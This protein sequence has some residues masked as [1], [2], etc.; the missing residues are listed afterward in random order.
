MLKGRGNNSNLLKDTKRSVRPS[1][2][3]SHNNSV[4]NLNNDR[5]LPT[6]LMGKLIRRKG[7]DPFPA[8]Q[9][10]HEEHWQLEENSHWQLATYSPFQ[11]AQGLL[12]AAQLKMAYVFL[13]V[14]ARDQMEGML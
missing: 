4:P 12:H 2:K 1:Y 10:I 11:A 7:G 14:C 8:A 6:W 13:E 3:N 5:G 9:S